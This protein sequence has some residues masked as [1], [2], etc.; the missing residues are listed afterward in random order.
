MKKLIFAVLMATLFFSLLNFIYCNLD[1]SVFGYKI[2]FKFTVPY[3]FALQ[4]SPLPMGFVL[5][6]AF[7]AGMITIALLEA[8]PSFFKTLEIRSKNKKIRQLERELDVVRGLG[9]VKETQVEGN[10]TPEQR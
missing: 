3:L 1:E 4:S 10:E 8:L 9:E 5:L 7:C 2:V 6:V